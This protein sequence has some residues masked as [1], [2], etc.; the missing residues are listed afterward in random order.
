MNSERVGRYRWTICALLFFATTINYVDRQVLGLLAPLLQK[1]I[2]W[3]EA[4]YAAIVSWFTAAYALGFLGVGRLMDRFGTRKGMAW[5]IVTWSIAGMSH[6]LASTVGGFSA[7]RF[8]LGLGESGNFPG[9][10]ATVAEWFPAKE[11]ALA[12]G[13]FNAGSNVGAILVPIFVPGIVARW[14]W[15]AAFLITGALGLIWLAAWLVL[16]QRPTEHPKVTKGELAYIQSDAPERNVSISWREL[17]RHRQTWAFALGKFLT[18]PIARRG[19]RSLD[20]VNRLH[21]HH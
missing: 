14:G 20:S 18:D 1:E 2:G 13:I 7:A 15:R 10:I 8:A 9:A 11:R 16:Y 3:N 21:D 17:L 19:N 5:S 4:D 6:A 12:T